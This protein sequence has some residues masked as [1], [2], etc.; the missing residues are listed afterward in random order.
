MPSPL[1]HC[2]PSG[3]SEPLAVLRSNQGAVGQLLSTI[4]GTLVA[5]LCRG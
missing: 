2:P 3:K 4:F 1:F 5:G